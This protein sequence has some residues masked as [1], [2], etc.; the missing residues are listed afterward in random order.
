VKDYFKDLPKPRA[1][2]SY[3][4]SNI[5]AGLPLELITNKTL[6][7]KIGDINNYKEVVFAFDEKKSYVEDIEVEFTSTDS[8]LRLI[9]NT[10][11]APDG[12]WQFFK[13]Q[14]SSK[15]AY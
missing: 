9:W 3:C 6:S 10:L 8:R 13:S 15:N 14:F 7:K 5:L 11:V 2:T 4:S 1:Q 12:N